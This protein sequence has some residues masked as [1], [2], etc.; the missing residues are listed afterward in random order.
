MANIKAVQ[1]FVDQLPGPDQ[2]KPQPRDYWQRLDVWHERILTERLHDAGLITKRLN[3]LGLGFLQVLNLWLGL[4][5]ETKNKAVI[6]QALA[7]CIAK[8]PR[9]IWCQDLFL[10]IEF[11]ENSIF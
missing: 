7:G 11:V 1:R 4:G 6:L 9:Q 5:V 8:N 2:I 10:L 3:Q